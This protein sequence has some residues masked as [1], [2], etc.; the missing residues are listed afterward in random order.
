MMAVR[1]DQI[2]ALVQQE[3]REL[4]AVEKDLLPSK[5]EMAKTVGLQAVSG[6]GQIG[7]YML[8]GISTC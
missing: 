4:K 3:L 6:A 1:E 7:W 2:H 8:S 5:T